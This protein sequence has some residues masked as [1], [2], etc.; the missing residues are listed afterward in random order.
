MG[1][2]A[3]AAV[4]EADYPKA[5]RWAERALAQN[6]RFA[7]ALRAL[8]VAHVGLGQPE[9][10]RQ[11]VAELLEI[12]PELTVSGFLARIPFPVAALGQRYAEALALAGLPA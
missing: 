2:G 9:R 10:A 3:V 4:S 1:T 11:A 12:E 6:R 5:I 7:V 8:A